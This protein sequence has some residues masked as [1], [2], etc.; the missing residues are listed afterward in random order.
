MLSTSNA[1]RHRLLLMFCSM[2]VSSV[3]VA[4]DVLSIEEGLALAKQNACLACHQVDIKRV[5]PGFAQIAQRYSEHTDA[6]QM[7]A[8]SI[9][10]GSW[11][12]WG[13]VPMPAQR[14]VST[15]QAQQLA[16]WIL[17]LTQ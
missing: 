11:K 5:G 1:T 9:R 12:K 7:L 16:Q 10:N 8:Q 2:P 13:A 14:Q 6:H 17:S 15:E 3:T 4:S